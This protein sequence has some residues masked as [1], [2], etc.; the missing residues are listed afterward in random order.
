MI[1]L[2]VWMDYW[3]DFFAERIRRQT[4]IHKLGRFSS[5]R[6]LRRKSAYDG[7][8]PPE[9]DSMSNGIWVDKCLTLP[10]AHI[11]VAEVCISGKLSFGALT[12]NKGGEISISIICGGKVQARYVFK[13]TDSVFTWRTSVCFPRHSLWFLS[14]S[15]CFVPAA[16]G[17]NDDT[18]T[19]SWRVT[20][21]S[22]GQDVL[23]DC[24][25]GRSAVMRPRL[26]AP[27][28]AVVAYH[29]DTVSG[30]SQG[31]NGMLAACKSAG[32][33]LEH[34]DLGGCPL[35]GHE[36]GSNKKQE[37]EYAIIHSNFSTINF[38][39]RRHQRRFQYCSWLVG[40]W[41]W[42]QQHL[43][44]TALAGF[45][46]LD[47]VWV[48]S[49]FVQ[50]AVTAFAP[51]PVFRVP[52]V[53]EPPSALS[54]ARASLGF[55]TNRI[56]SLVVCDL[57]SGAYRK[58][59]EAAIDAFVLAN[60]SN[61]NGFLVVKL[62]NA[63][64]HISDLHNIRSRLATV[65]NSVVITKVLTRQEMWVLMS[66]CDIL[67]ALHR[68]EGF[69][70]CLAEM[71]ALGK[72]VIATGWSGNTDFMNSDNSCLV[73]FQLHALGNEH[74]FGLFSSN[75][76]WAEPNVANAAEWLIKCY[77]NPEYR[78]YLGSAAATNIRDNLSANAVGTIVK[79]RLA[80]ISSFSRDDL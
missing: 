14:C 75:D 21:L 36:P 1:K 70:L 40:Y 80:I 73:D 49:S 16:L 6:L 78:E 51:I 43:P 33:T 58:N 65:P 71:M 64:K 32:L 24:G 8:Y 4:V 55:P 50:S 12:N 13:P 26:L 9:P 46:Y 57:S 15:H 68:A 17:D 53:V 18:R 38:D 59:P 72:V 29:S 56:I 42:E 66:S 41:A 20:S 61:T 48:P 31:G 76:L 28:K 47:E 45:Q 35:M 27:V 77:E 79:N 19:L 25:R 2:R 62:L 37:C 63:D 11:G 52:H 7:L 67:L 34:L 60:T 74:A 5:P 54:D 44:S 30:I 10:V 3:G 22:V 39:L 23:I 69:G